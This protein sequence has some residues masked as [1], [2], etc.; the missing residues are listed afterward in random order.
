MISFLLKVDNEMA[1]L[2]WITASLIERHDAFYGAVKS[3]VM[4]I[5]FLLRVAN[6]LP[7][8]NWVIGASFGYTASYTFVGYSAFSRPDDS[9]NLWRTSTL[10]VFSWSSSAHLFVMHRDGTY[11]FHSYSHASFYPYTFL[12]SG[13]FF[14][15]FSAFPGFPTLFGLL[16]SVSIY[17]LLL[18]AGRGVRFFPL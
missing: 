14:A 10:C 2:K 4:M 15:C 7:E 9:S 17:S 13:S 5:S 8:L 12:S 3:R 11:H 1:E 6:E 16:A 18:L